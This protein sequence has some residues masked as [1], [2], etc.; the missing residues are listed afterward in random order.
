MVRNKRQFN[1]EGL[2][3]RRLLSANPGNFQAGNSDNLVAVYSAQITA[4]GNS[5]IY[6]VSDQ[7]TSGPGVRAG[8]VQD[9]LAESGR[10]RDG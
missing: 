7:A 6:P 9:L 1:L 10:G 2:E 5:T 4:N 8:L 3:S